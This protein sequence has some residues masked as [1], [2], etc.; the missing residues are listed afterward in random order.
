MRAVRQHALGGPDVLVR[1]GSCRAGARAD[2]GARRG[3]PRPG[4]EPGRL[5]DR[6]RVAGSSASCRSRSAGTSPASSRRSAS[7]SPGS[8][9]ATAC[10]G[11]RASRGRR[12]ATR[13][14]SPRRRGTW[15][16][17][18]KGLSDVEAAAIPLAG[19][20]A[21]QALVDTAAS[22]RGRAC[23][24]S[25]RPAGSGTSRCRS[26]RRAARGWPARRVSRSTI[27]C[28][29]PRGRRAA[30]QERRPRSVEVDVVLDAVGGDAGLAAL[31]AMRDGGSLVTALRVCGP[32]AA[33]GGRGRVRVAGILV[34]PDRAG[35]EELAAHRAPA[36]RRRDVPARG[37]GARITS[38]ASRA[39]RVGRSSCTILMARFVLVHG[40]FGGAWCWEPVI[41][42]L[43][44]AGHTVV[45]RSTCPAA[46][47]TGRRSRRSRS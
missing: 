47:T 25:A 34:E 20:T 17:P 36:A 3:S 21:W 10:S 43:E 30:R 29:E 41:P 28:A 18:R 16:G 26:R 13:S 24:C 6:G 40:A 44:A 14:T 1:R 5:E 7:A 45:R 11:C 23:S 32:G 46:A 39:A 38:S 4:V 35:L 33:R 2:R 19:L 15:R 22:A 31:P 37:G 12:P 8:R 42:P 27:S 9:P